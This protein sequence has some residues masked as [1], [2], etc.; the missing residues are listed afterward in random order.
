[1]LNGLHHVGIAVA[2]IDTAV[3]LYTETL[4]AS[5]IRRG[6]LEGLEFALVDS[7]G[8]ELELLA[9]RDTGTGIGKFVAERGPGL[10]H[11]AFAVDDIQVEILRL[12]GEGFEQSGEVRVGVHGTPI[13][14]FHPKT[15]GGVL[16][17]LVAAHA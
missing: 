6:S 5:L 15:V 8:M 4:S 13:V 16:T 14:F 7:G 9:S 2:D 3:R 1:V 17:E 12:V 11:L 10:H